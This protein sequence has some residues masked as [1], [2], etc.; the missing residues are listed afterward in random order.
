MKK[1]AIAFAFVLSAAAAMAETTTATSANV[2]GVLRVD[3]KAAKTI[4]AVPWEKTD[5]NGGA[6]DVASVVKTANLTAGD[7][8][9]VY[10]GRESTSASESK[11]R[12]NTWILTEGEG[13]VLYWANSAKQ[14]IAN[15]EVDKAPDAAEANIARGTAFILERENPTNSDG[16]AKPFY[17]FG[18]VAASKGSY[19]VVAGS[20][21]YPCF[22]L[23]AA[24][25]TAGQRLNSLDWDGS[26]INALDSICIP[27][28]DGSFQTVLQWKDGKWKYQGFDKGASGL[29]PGVAPAKTWIEYTGTI[30]AG[31]GIWYVSKG[32]TPTLNWTNVPSM[33]NN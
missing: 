28:A 26:K 5:V 4:V 13:G 17:L 2:F 23:I 24:P 1:S 18:Q 30:P 12:Y 21:H 6:I 15:G 33:A 29:P 8:I 19:T 11:S 9:F 32:G 14:V 16:S 20:N 22:N 25:A 7:K 10:D 3:S 31:T 27:S